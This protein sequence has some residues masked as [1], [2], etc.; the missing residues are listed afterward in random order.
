MPTNNSANHDPVQ[1]NVVVGA[2]SGGISSVAP[3]ATS[4]VPLISGGSSANPSFGTAVVAGGGTG[5]ATTTAYGLITGGTTATG[6]FQ[7]V[8]P[9]TAHTVVTSGGTGALHTYTSAFKIT[10]DVMTNT[11]QP[12]FLAYANANISNVTGDG[13]Y[14]IVVFNTKVYDQATNFGTTTFTAP[15]TG[16]YLLTALVTINGVTSS[17]TAGTLQIVTTARTYEYELSPAKT[18]DSNAEV[19]YTITCIAD[20]TAGDTATVPLTIYG[21]TKIVGVVGSATLQSYFSGYLVC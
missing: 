17:N 8:T 1:Y 16:K 2:A 9:G 18:F 3:S 21:G 10:S 11:A 15:S 5:I 13:T 19:P 6:A 7:T 20:M 4:G 14:Y 12:A